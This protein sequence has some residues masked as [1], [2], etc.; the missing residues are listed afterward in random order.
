MEQVFWLLDGRV[1]GR[2]GPN[3]DPW[4]L[5]ELA[6]AE[7]SAILSVNKGEGCHTDRISQLG[8][9][10]ANV[11]MSENAP[12]RTGDLE[13]C[14]ANLPDAIAFIDEH[15][16]KGP[17]LIHC[18]SG[19]DRTGLVMAAYLIARHDKT[20]TQAMEAVKAVR[21]IAFSAE[22]WM[23]YCYEVLS[24]FRTMLTQEEGGSPAH[25]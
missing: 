13:L 6:E 14:L 8:M 7:F 10:Y 11:P 23:D 16:R 1:A 12:P 5:E 15:C 21:P 4:I 17:V 20:V 24:R 19:K 18:R 9:A 22:G 2:S 25:G 3:K